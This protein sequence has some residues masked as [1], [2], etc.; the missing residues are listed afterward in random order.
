[1]GM[2]AVFVH[3]AEKYFLSGQ[4][5]WITEETKG[6]IADRVADLKP[7]LIGQIAPNFRMSTIGGGVQE[8]HKVKAEV[9]VVYFW[10]PSCSHCKK[11]TPQLRD[12]YN[13]Y[14]DKGLEV[15]AVY[16]QGEKDKWSEYV[17]TNKLTWINV[18]DPTRVSRY[19]KLYDIYSTPVM[20]VLDKDKK[21]VAKRIGVE[22]L[23][24]FIEQEVL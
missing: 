18:W 5:P 14:K 21:I 3:I 9:T 13:K 4:T 23:E 10:E 19:H 22:S 20:Y 7:N 16:T 15:V 17:D 11:V 1:M 24:R 8:L 12:I 2:D 6:K